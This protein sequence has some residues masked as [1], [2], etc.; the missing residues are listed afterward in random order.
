MQ[1]RKRGCLNYLLLW[2]ISLNEERPLAVVAKLGLT[3]CGY[4]DGNEPFIALLLY[5]FR[6][7]VI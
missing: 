2:C 4:L 7:G 5:S 3:K 6:E 1:P